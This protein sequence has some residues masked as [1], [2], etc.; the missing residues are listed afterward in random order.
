MKLRLSGCLDF[1]GLQEEWLKEN[2][3]CECQIFLFLIL[4][5]FLLDTGIKTFLFII[6]SDETKGIFFPH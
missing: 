3:S 1:T 5:L 4:F 6:I 2:C